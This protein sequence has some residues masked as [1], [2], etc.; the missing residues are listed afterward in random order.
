MCDAEIRNETV[1]VELRSDLREFLE[2]EA[3]HAGMTLSQY[4]REAAIARAIA[5]RMLSDQARF[6]R[7]ARSVRETMAD[8]AVARSPHAADLVLA[9]MT[10]LTA[11]EL[12]DGPRASRRAQRAGRL[13]AQELADRRTN[14]TRRGP[15]QTDRRAR[16]TR[17]QHRTRRIASAGA[18]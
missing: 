16:G 18:G 11:I 13:Q 5:G 15:S 2:S 9:A 8:D 1:E 12:T 10:R 14:V 6:E 7:L 17:D 3:H 4:I